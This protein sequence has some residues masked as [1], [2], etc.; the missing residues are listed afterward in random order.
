M[1]SCGHLFSFPSH[2]EPQRGDS[3]DP[4]HFLL[5]AKCDPQESNV[6]QKQKLLRLPGAGDS[7]LNQGSG[8]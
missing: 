2:L 8:E 4:W 5:Q 1:Y 7:H 6:R 3:R